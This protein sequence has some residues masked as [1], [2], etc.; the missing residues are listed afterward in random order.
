MRQ[1]EVI[2]SGR[3]DVPVLDQRE[4]QVSVEALLQLRHVLHPHDA[5]DADLLPLLLVAQRGRHAAAAA[6]GSSCPVRS[7]VGEAAR[8]LVLFTREAPPPRLLIGA[9]GGRRRRPGRP[10]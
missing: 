1:R 5:P 9:G 8:E 2:V 6:R 7:G 10:S 4:V 3:G